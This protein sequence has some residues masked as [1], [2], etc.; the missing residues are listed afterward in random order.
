MKYA[1]ILKTTLKSGEFRSTKGF[2][3]KHCHDLI[4]A[5]YTII[6]INVTSTALITQ[7][8][9]A[10]PDDSIGFLWNRMHGSATTMSAAEERDIRSD[11]IPQIFACLTAKLTKN[12]T[13]YCDSCLTGCLE[14]NF[15]NNV[16]FAFAKLTVTLP[17]VQIVAPSEVS[18]LDKFSILANSSFKFEII[19]SPTAS[20]NIAVVLGAATKELL[21]HA[22]NTG[23]PLDTIQ[24]SLRN[25]ISTG[26]VA[27]M[28]FYGIPDGLL[29]D[30][31]YDLELTMLLAIMRIQQQEKCLNIVSTLVEKLYVSLQPVADSTRTP[32]A[33]E[34]AT[35]LSAAICAKKPDVVAYLLQ[36][37]AD[38]FVTLHGQTLYD[39]VQE[40]AQDDAAVSSSTVEY[41]SAILDILDE[42]LEQQQ[43]EQAAHSAT[44]RQRLLAAR[45][46]GDA[47]ANANLIFTANPATDTGDTVHA[48]PP[49]NIP[50]PSSM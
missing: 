14:N 11:N 20:T 34:H 39:F 48:T 28:S 25:S 43:K 44:S 9:S 49:V 33:W 45:S 8:L 15:Y 24:G 31:H 41:Y 12:A 18:H 17:D 23:I 1:I 6:T 32:F 10:L 16:Q 50:K 27:A 40:Q 36:N 26:G 30:A 38:P 47:A 22:I 21:Y 19:E 42:H 46:E 7:Q 5:G 35:F 37:G 2:Y 4:Q 13:I 3:N 29:I